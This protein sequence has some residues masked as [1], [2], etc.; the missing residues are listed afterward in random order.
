MAAVGRFGFGAV[1]DDFAT[2]EGAAVEVGGC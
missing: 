2:A 1:G